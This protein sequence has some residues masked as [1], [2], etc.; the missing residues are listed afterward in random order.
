M[1]WKKI[2]IDLEANNLLAPMLDYSTMPYKLKDTARLWCI[3]VRDEETEQSVLLL[4]EEVLDEQ[5]PVAVIEYYTNEP[6]MELSL[7][8]DGE[9][10]L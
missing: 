2:N 8:Q 3:S 6:E 4:P 7:N 10:K 1:A 9:E 5:A